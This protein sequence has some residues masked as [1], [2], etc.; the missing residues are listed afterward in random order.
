[1]SWILHFFI[2]IF[3]FPSL[4]EGF[5]F[6][7]LEAMSCGTPVIASKDSSTVNVN[8][9][10]IINTKTCVSAYK[11]KQEFIGAILKIINSHCKNYNKKKDM[12]ENS[13]IIFVKDS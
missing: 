4:Y 5:G 11:K 9:S 7:P 3:I 10:N 12:D 2:F 8:N 1:M 6:P 13:K